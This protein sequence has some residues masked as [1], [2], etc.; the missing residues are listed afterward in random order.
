MDLG[1]FL[2]DQEEGILQD[3]VERVRCSHL[4]SYAR[5][6]REQVR[7]RLANLL[8]LVRDAVRERDLGPMIAHVDAIALERFEAG[9]G[10]FEVQT[11]F[12]V[13]EEVI[14]QRILSE[15]QPEEFPEAI[16]LVS[17]A[18]GAGKDRLACRYVSLASASKVRSLDLS[19]MFKGTTAAQV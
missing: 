13:L 5:T 4:E 6:G 15:I 14:W 10:L 3:A 7:A 12:N 17:T 19:A 9:F 8:E 2:H 18:L 16:G 1:R 11:A